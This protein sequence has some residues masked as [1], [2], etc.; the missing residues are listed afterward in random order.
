[1]EIEGR[2]ETMATVARVLGIAVVAALLGRI[3]ARRQGAAAKARP[4]RFGEDEQEL[5]P[6][7]LGLE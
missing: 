3:V 6:M 4:H 5:V 1:M 2:S 7:G